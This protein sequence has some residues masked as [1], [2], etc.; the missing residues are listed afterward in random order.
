MQTL[1]KLVY[2]RQEVEDLLGIC[3]TTLFN[4]IK[5]GKIKKV[6]NIGR[7]VKITREEIQRVLGLTEDKLA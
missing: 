2:T 7:P 5:D 1:S 3:R 6:P 4:W